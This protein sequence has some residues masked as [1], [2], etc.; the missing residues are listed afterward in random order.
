MVRDDGDHRQRAE[1][2]GKRVQSIVRDHGGGFR[3]CDGVWSIVD[4]DMQFGCSPTRSAP[5]S[6]V[7]V[8]P[9]VLREYLTRSILRVY[10]TGR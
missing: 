9:N 10:Q 2:V 8:D 7:E 3:R 4:M 5:E 1:R 6:M